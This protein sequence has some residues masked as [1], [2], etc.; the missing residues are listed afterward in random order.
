MSRHIICQNGSCFCQATREGHSS[1]RA[2]TGRRLP[3]CEYLLERR[4]LR[5]FHLAVLS[6]RLHDVIYHGPTTSL[7]LL[8]D[9]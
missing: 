9:G 5:L 2:R 6:L 3:C 4:L 1:K 7:N 8:I